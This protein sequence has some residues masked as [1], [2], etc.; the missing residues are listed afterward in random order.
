MAMYSKKTMKTTQQIHNQNSEDAPTKEE[1]SIVT[2]NLKNNKSPVS[3]SLQA[4][5]FKH[6]GEKLY[7]ELWR[8]I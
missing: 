4:E 1:C 6:G 2:R 8:L 5:M 3:N 7:K